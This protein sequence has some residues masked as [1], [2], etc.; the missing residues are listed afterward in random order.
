MKTWPRSVVMTTASSRLAD[1]ASVAPSCFLR[2]FLPPERVVVVQQTVATLLAP[3]TS[4]SETTVSDATSQTVTLSAEPSTGSA[5]AKSED[6]G[7][8]APEEDGG[9]GGERRCGSVLAERGPRRAAW[10]P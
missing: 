10:V 7:L 9:G 3:S 5:K 2:F 8:N 1:S 4:H 6:D